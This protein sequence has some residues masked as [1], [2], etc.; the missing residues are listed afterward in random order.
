MFKCIYD[1]DLAEIGEWIRVAETEMESISSRFVFQIKY[2]PNGEI[3]AFCRWTPRGY[4]EQ[5]GEHY[6]PEDIFAVCQSST[7][8]GV[9]IEPTC[10]IIRGSGSTHQCLTSYVLDLV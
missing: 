1:M 9:G 6:D 10:T 4:E 3:E 2:R 7:L 5:P 8:R